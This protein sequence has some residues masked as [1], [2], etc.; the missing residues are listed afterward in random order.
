MQVWIGNLGKYNEGYLVGDWFDLPIDYD[1][2][3]ERIGLNE[4]YEEYG[5]FDTDDFPCE[6]GEWTSVEELNEMYEMFE[7]LPDY[8]LDN[9][10]EFIGIFGSLKN[11]VEHV[12]DIILYSGCD[13]M[14]EVAEVLLEE[15]GRLDEIPED[16][17]Y[18]FDYEAYGRDLWIAGTFISTEKGMCEVLW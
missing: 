18:Y 12:N 3:A 14:G 8:V 1:D 5:I 17:Q 10:D 11:L 16:L 2:M 4:R 13:T 7:E 6:V 15:S 9:L